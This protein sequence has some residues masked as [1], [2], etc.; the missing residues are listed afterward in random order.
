M[1]LPHITAFTISIFAILS[2]ASETAVGQYFDTRED[3]IAGGV[4]GAIIGG[5]IGN[6]NDET[7]EGIAIGAA[8]GALAGNAVGRDRNQA[9]LREQA[10]RQAAYQRQL[11]SRQS[12]QQAYQNAASVQDVISMSQNGIGPGVITRHLQKVGLQKEIG[13][14]DIIAMSRSGVPESV[15]EFMQQTRNPTRKTYAYPDPVRPVLAPVYRPV[16]A[17][18]ITVERVVPAYRPCPPGAGRRYGAYSR[19]YGHHYMR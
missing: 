9:Y 14:P 4:A 12:Q 5:I 6:Q 19:G 11:A 10:Y 2:C 8:L 1:N 17:P 7:P 15:I 16:A 18:V 13:V 3:T